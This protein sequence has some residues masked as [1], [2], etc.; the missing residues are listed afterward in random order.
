MSALDLSGWAGDGL[1]LLLLAALF[2]VPGLLI[3]AC[4][5]LIARMETEGN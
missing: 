5:R 3:P 4:R 2:A 1:A